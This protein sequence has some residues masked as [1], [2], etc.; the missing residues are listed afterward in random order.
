MAINTYF[1]KYNTCTHY[2]IAS[3]IRAQI[4][5]KLNSSDQKKLRYD[6]YQL[7]RDLE[8]VIGVNAILVGPTYVE[9]KNDYFEEI[10]CLGRI[11][12]LFCRSKY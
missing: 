4:L 10:S 2:F 1:K 8:T 11:T 12:C 6:C 5:T 9:D 3:K 7:K